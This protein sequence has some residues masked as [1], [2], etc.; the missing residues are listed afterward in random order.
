M[1]VVVVGSGGREHALGWIIRRSPR[2]REV[3]GL[4]GNPGWAGLGAVWSELDPL[5]VAVV[6]ERCRRESVDL[7]VVGPEAPLVAGLADALRAAGIRVFGPGAEGARLEGSKAFA[8]AFM[9]RHGIRTA[10]F[11]VFETL[12]PALAYV[13]GRGAPIVVK[14][15]GLA[16]GK[17]VVVAATLEEAE[18]ALRAM[19]GSRS[20]GEAAARVVI[21]DVLP[22]EE[23]SVLALCDGDTIMALAPSQDH[24]RIFDGDRGPNTGGMG[25]YVP[26]TLV[27]DALAARIER[28]VLAPSLAGLRADGIDFRGILYCGL[29]VTD[30]VPWVLEYNVRFGD[31]ECQALMLHLADD[32]VPWL[33]ATAERRLGEMP[34]P[35]W[36]EGSTVCVVM[37]AAG[38][39]GTPRKGDE[40]AGLNELQEEEEVVVFH[41]GT[42]RRADGAVVTAGGR[43]LSVTAHGAD[44]AEARRRAYAVVDRLRW[45]GAQV[46]SDIGERELRRRR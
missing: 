23:V 15:D 30:G 32:L 3:I 21:E 29:M 42:A 24:K 12:E 9:R 11:E 5:D 4:P 18:A 8:K 13:R 35:R 31:P 10:P 45:D 44:L 33:E 26:T 37:A 25:A 36:R 20:L 16:A 41:A 17:G 2:V 38:Y 22:G 14:A 19:L 6:V 43:V 7:V 39:P 46:R 40:I 28:D 34:P 1:R 27:D